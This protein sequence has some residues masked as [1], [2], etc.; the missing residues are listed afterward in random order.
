MPY[1]KSGRDLCRSGADEAQEISKSIEFDG[2]DTFGVEFA[3]AW[4]T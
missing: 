1:R 2:K 3:T 4:M